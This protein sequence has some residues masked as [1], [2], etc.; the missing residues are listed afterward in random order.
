MSYPDSASLVFAAEET[1]RTLKDHLTDP[2]HR[3]F[4]YL[5]EESHNKCSRIIRKRRDNHKIVDLSEIRTR[6]S[7]RG[8]ERDLAYEDED[9]DED[10][11]DY[12]IQYDVSIF[13]NAMPENDTQE[14]YI[15]YEYDSDDE[16]L[17]AR[18]RDKTHAWFCHATNPISKWPEE[19]LVKR[20][21]RIRVDFPD[22][23][24]V[25]QGAVES[26]RRVLSI[27][28]NCEPSY[29]FENQIR[30]PS[31]D[32]YNHNQFDDHDD[33]HDHD[34]DDDDDK[35]GITRRN[36][37][38]RRNNASVIHTKDYN[39]N[40]KKKMAT[41]S[42]INWNT[43]PNF[44]SLETLLHNACIL[45]SYRLRDQPYLIEDSST[46]SIKERHMYYKDVS[47]IITS[48]IRN[49]F[50]KTAGL[51]D[52]CSTPIQTVI[53]STDPRHSM[54][55]N[56]MKKPEIRVEVTVP[57]QLI[58][59]IS[60]ATSSAADAAM[61]ASAAVDQLSMI[62]ATTSQAT[63]L[64][65]PSID[66]EPFL[67]ASTKSIELCQM[68]L[69][70]V[71]KSI[72][73][74]QNQIG[75]QSSRYDERLANQER[76]IEQSIQ[77]KNLSMEH[78]M[79]NVMVQLDKIQIT[80]RNDSS[81]L[82]DRIIE[83]QVAFE[84]R[85]LWRSLNNLSKQ[86]SIDIP[87]KINQSSSCQDMTDSIDNLYVQISEREKAKL[88]MDQ[89]RKRDA[90]IDIN[91]LNF[92]GGESV[93]A[94]I[95][96][97][98]IHVEDTTINS[99]SKLAIDCKDPKKITI[100]HEN[101]ISTN[102]SL[103]SKDHEMPPLSALMDLTHTFADVDQSYPR[104]TKKQQQQEEEEEEKE[105]DIEEEERPALIQLQLH[106]IVEK[107][108]SLV[109]NVDKHSGDGNNKQFATISQSNREDLEP[110]TITTVHS[111][112]DDDIKVTHTDSEASMNSVRKD[113]DVV[114]GDNDVD[115]NN[116]QD[117]D[118]DEKLR[119]SLLNRNK[120]PLYSNRQTNN[121]SHKSTPV[122][123]TTISRTFAHN[124][125]NKPLMSTSSLSIRMCQTC[126]RSGSTRDAFCLDCNSMQCLDCV[127]Q[128]HLSGETV[129]HRIE[130]L[131]EKTLRHG[132]DQ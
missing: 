73:H 60:M 81:I 113:P 27:S 132:L 67:Q 109:H 82:Y 77:S 7:Q 48:C 98:H 1:F 126:M 130:Y 31:S 70:E 20:C 23:D 43:S 6:K 103:P 62:A 106:R 59:K 44:I 2:I 25:F 83:N 112:A 116:D 24:K 12:N 13:K 38:K 41:T 64:P 66:P 91:S 122:P 107:E 11:D 8:P 92:F 34:N 68:M 114:K 80:Q 115:G 54:Y 102:K 93:T 104:N 90:E 129:N 119:R 118:E 32:T 110:K 35:N 69:T 14:E 100:N 124:V 65:A 79:T 127:T 63:P 26:Y 56:Q 37:D 87:D 57:D 97:P 4:R 52:F 5:Y 101:L 61:S 94:E 111:R 108:Q 117:E 10:D 30:S 3:I 9:E 125:N 36:N 86:Y 21:A 55:M 99:E 71:T 42:K 88:I 29:I 16:E 95:T 47:Q 22:I 45:T 105:K 58:E 72:G 19:E 78:C 28:K 46:V 85:L 40:D 33:D 74:I 123:Q 84:K 121:S 76:R 120:T 17:Q 15:L 49:A 131:K 75:Q 51:A 18:I 39:Y 128:L 53:A 96:P 50:A 89:K